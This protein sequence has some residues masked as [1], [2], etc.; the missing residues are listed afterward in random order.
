MPLTQLDQNVL[1]PVGVSKTLGPALQ[2]LLQTRNFLTGDGDRCH[3]WK[4]RLRGSLWPMW[5][6]FPEEHI[7]GYK[8]QGF[9]ITA[10]D[11]FNGITEATLDSLRVRV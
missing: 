8:D 1:S 6:H 5:T 3:R 10:S 4:A 11:S 7:E 2:A 9:T